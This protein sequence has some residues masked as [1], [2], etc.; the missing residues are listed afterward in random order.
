MTEN[1]DGRRNVVRHPALIRTWKHIAGMRSR[2]IEDSVLCHPSSVIRFGGTPP[3]SFLFLRGP[4][5]VGFRC[6]VQ[7]GRSEGKHPLTRDT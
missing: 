6:D 7:A 4:S 3:S 1:R 2:E 5:G